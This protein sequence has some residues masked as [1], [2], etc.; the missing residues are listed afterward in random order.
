MVGRQCRR[1]SSAR[2]AEDT[3]HGSG[4]TTDATSNLFPIRLFA[5]LEPQ[6]HLQPERKTFIAILR[7]SPKSHTVLMLDQL[8][9]AVY[10]ALFQKDTNA[11]DMWPLTRRW[12][13]LQGTNDVVCG[14]TVWN[15]L[16]CF[17]ALNVHNNIH[18]YELIQSTN[19]NCSCDN[20]MME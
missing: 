11:F 7:C 9:L 12:V 8:S 19:N 10:H 20:E 3:E 16:S 13:R 4:P 15:S 17:F 5:C 2:P 1:P 14:T 6:T 18:D